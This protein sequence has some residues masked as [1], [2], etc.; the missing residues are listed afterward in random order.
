M[1]KQHPYLELPNIFYRLTQPTAVKKPELVLYNQDLARLLKLDKL[2]ESFLKTISGQDTS[3]L[4]PFA[5][6]YMGHQFGHQTMLGDGRAI[7]LGKLNGFDLQIKGSGQTPYSRGGDGLATLKAMLREHL[8]SE[9]IYKLKIPTTRSLAVIKTNRQ[10][11]RKDL[12][13]G[14]IS[15]RL[16][17]SHIRVGTFEFANQQASFKDLKSLADL[18][19]KEL[20]PYLLDAKLPYLSLL[21]ITIKKQAEL[22][23]KHQLV[24][25]VHGVMNTDNML[26]SG[27]TIDYGPCAFLDH[28]EPKSV[29]SSIDLK[30]RYAYDQQPHIGLFNLTRFAE[31]LIPLIDQDEEKAIEMAETELASY[32]ELFNHYYVNGL[33]NKLGFMTSNNDQIINQFLLILKTEK[34]DYTESF[35]LISLDR[36]NLKEMS[37][38][39]KDWYKKFQHL[40]PDKQLMRS[41]NPAFIPRNYLLDQAL[42]QGEIKF[43]LVKQLLELSS[44]PYAYT[45]EQLNYSFPMSQR[46]HLIKTYCGT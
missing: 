8:I 20:Y 2:T 13:P 14:A 40:K 25:F 1:I 6:S 34:L 46:F 30:G 36:P 32:T 24:G 41:V 18:T 38:T 28:Y 17:K 12:E 39:F 9:A 33:R 10:V 42:N 29:F 44:D 7:M 23:A 3:D 43:D 15:V 45:E 35:R 31:T 37:Q 5:Q 19:L 22:I 11:M 4:I 16:A 21:R 27:E 26:I